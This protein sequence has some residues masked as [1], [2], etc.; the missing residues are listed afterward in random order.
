MEPGSDCTAFGIVVPD[1]PGCFSAG[2][3]RDEAIANV[4]NAI[5]MSLEDYQSD[6]IGIPSATPLDVLR[7]RPEFRGWTW[8]IVRVKL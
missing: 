4:R 1:L 7:V 5:A 8:A 2:D 6:G 3:S